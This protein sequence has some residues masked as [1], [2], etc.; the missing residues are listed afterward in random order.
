[1]TALAPDTWQPG[2]W[3]GVSHDRYHSDKFGSVPTLSRTSAAELLRSP[4]KARHCHPRLGAYGQASTASMVKGGILHS[5]I[6][7]VGPEIAVIAGFDDYKKK[8]AQELRDEALLSGRQPLLENRLAE[9]QATVAGVKASCL[10]LLGVDLDA[11]DFEP[12][13]TALWA[14]KGVRVRTRFDLLHLGAG[15]VLDPKFVKSANPAAWCCEAYNRLQGATYP[16]ALEAVKPALAG[17]VHF[18]F[19]LCETEPPYDV[20]LVDLGGVDQQVGSM[21]WETAIERWRVGLERGIWPAYGSHPH[22]TQ[23]RSWELQAALEREL[24]AEQ[25]EGAEG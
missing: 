20:S 24:M 17:R 25:P 3:T 6:F 22:Q 15:R 7:G 14:Y 10:E 23:G 1:M 13:V 21:E 4:R 19:L 9:Y 8:A 11:G 2:L 18:S 5:L 12:E 16:L